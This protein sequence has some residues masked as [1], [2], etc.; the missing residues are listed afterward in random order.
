MAQPPALQTRN[1]TNLTDDPKKDTPDPNK[2][3]AEPKQK[4]AKATK[5]IKSA[6]T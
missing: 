5:K 4:F 2:Q 1:R 3:P 6:M